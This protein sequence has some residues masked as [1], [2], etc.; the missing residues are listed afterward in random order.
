M[1]FSFINAAA[2][3]TAES[4]VQQ[5]IHELSNMSGNELLTTVLDLCLKFGLKII[6]ATAIFIVGRIIIRKTNHITEKI[7]LKRKVEVS[8]ASFIKSIVS[9]SLMIFLI[10]IIIGTIGIDTSSFVALFAS[11]GVAIGMALSGTLQNFAG[12]FMILLFKPFKVGDFIEAQGQLGTVKEIQ[13]TCT[14]LNTPDNK[15]IYVP[16]GSLSTGI[17]NNF[18]KETIRRVDRSFGIAYGD[19]FY[20]AKEVILQLI[21]EDERIMKDPLPFIALG[22]LG[23]SSVNIT[24]RVWAKQVDYWA[25]FFDMNEKLYKTFGQK[26]INI[27]FPQLYVHVH[28][29]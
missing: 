26:G 12:G 11:A 22:S 10:I 24:V 17:I 3:K 28:Q 6:I 19:D 2:E 15:I 25:I 4:E 5:K 18:S 20:K 16:N 7:L 14:V 29:K 1:I 9:V 8:L 23:D 21:N 27:P 13:I